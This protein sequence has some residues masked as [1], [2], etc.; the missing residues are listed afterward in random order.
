M[1]LHANA[2]LGL[3]GL[4]RAVEDGCSLKST[5]LAFSVSPETA[6]RLRALMIALRARA[7]LG[8][9]AAAR[10]LRDPAGAGVEEDQVMSLSPSRLNS[11]I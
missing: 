11:V 9:Q 6:H 10:H 4:V 8:T 1:Y 5:A 7:F 2:K 3:A